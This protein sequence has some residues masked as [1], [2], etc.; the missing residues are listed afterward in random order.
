MNAK[1]YVIPCAVTA[2]LTSVVFLGLGLCF[3]TMAATKL[4]LA[5]AKAREQQYEI[6]C[7]GIRSELATT[8]SEL[9]E[10]RAILGKLTNSVS[11]SDNAI[12]EIESITK[13]LQDYYLGSGGRVSNNGNVVVNR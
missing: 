3:K 1:G 12:A 7:K 10:S 2:I 8:R 5:D 6:I 11:N 4:E 9:E 13:D